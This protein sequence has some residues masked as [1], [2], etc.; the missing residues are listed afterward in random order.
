MVMLMLMVVLNTYYFVN[1]H[2]VKSNISECVRLPG[3]VT[4]THV[5]GV[6]SQ[7]RPA[8]STRHVSQT[9]AV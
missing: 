2:N 7:P 4:L 9:D 6:F 5:V 8:A 3:W 1:Q